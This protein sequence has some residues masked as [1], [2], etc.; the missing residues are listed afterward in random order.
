[1]DG[2]EVVATGAGTRLASVAAVT[3]SATRPR[4]PLAT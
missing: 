3:A 4:S 1:M 2:A